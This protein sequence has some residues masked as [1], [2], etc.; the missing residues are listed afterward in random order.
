MNPVWH[1][2]NGVPQVGLP[3]NFGSGVFV[4][5][6]TT[7]TLGAGV[8]LVFSGAGTLYGVATSTLGFQPVSGDMLFQFGGTNNAF[9]A[10]QRS[11]TQIKARLADNSGDAQFSCGNG[12]T[13]LAPLTIG[14]GTN[15]TVAAAGAIE[16]DGVSFYNTIDTTNGRRYDDSFNLFRLTASGTGITTI[17][18]FFGTNDGI[19]LV[20]GGV[21]RIHWHCKFSQ[22]TAGTAT[23][24]IVT[25]TT[26]LAHL[27]AQYVG[28]N[29][30]GQG[31]VGAPQ[32]AGVTATSSSS[33]ALPVT[34]TE[35]DAATHV[36]DIWAVVVAGAGAGNTRLRL[37]MS[38]GTATPLTNSYFTVER[39][40]AGNVGT[41][42][43]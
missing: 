29:I 27:S 38:A 14:S 25:A 10:L 17:A 42:V 39:L 4:I 3:I 5:A 28:T 1:F 20:S 40:P 31:A 21:Y 32:M 18:D 37:T 6:P 33:T 22:A 13:A 11:T 34:G 7:A 24:T 2:L 8:S 30:A 35:A 26:A 12:T 16:N 15:L 41:Y 9:P 36:F 19:P 23:W 43:A